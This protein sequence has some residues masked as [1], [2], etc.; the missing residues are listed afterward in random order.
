MSPER[1]AW[2]VGLGFALGA[3][4][5][6]CNDV[7]GNCDGKIDG[8]L[9]ELRIYNCSSDEMTVKV[10]ERTVG[11]V[12]AADEDGICGVTDLGSFPQCSTGKI[13]A[14]A[15]QTLTDKLKWSEDAVNL[16]PDGCWVIAVIMGSYTETEHF[17]LP[18]VDPI[19]GPECGYLEK[20]EY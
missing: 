10:N 14:Y 5:V 4:S 2:L 12:E 17:E 15:Y 19:T 16:N 20:V 8:D 18:A 13:E 9:Y 11:S 1:A 3:V 7:S 6:A